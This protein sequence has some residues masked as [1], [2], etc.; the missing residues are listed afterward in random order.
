M[1]KTHQDPIIAFWSYSAYPFLCCG[2][3]CGMA[4]NGL[5]KIEEM[6]G[7]CFKPLFIMNEQQGATLKQQLRDLKDEKDAAKK[8]MDA[9]YLCKLKDLLYEHGQKIEYIYTHGA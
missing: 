5:A 3:I 7:G 6:G 2:T 9:Q 8:E 4:R 1:S